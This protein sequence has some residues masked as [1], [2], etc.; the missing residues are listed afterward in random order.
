M[1]K[2]LIYCEDDLYKK[3]PT[4]SLGS[5]F[6]DVLL[7]YAYNLNT[8]PKPDFCLMNHGGLRIPFIP[9]GIITV[10]TA[11]ELMPFENELV[12]VT[13]EGIYCKKLFESI[14]IAGG[15]P[16]SGLKMTITPNQ[17]AK[18]ILIN[19]AEFDEN[20]T[21]HILTSD[22]LANGGDKAD[23]LTQAIQVKSL[24]IKIRDAFISQLQK[25]HHQGLTIKATNDERI[26]KSKAVY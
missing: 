24:N 3:L 21:Y 15:A 23:A 13:L 22:Y 14:A 2:E 6:C 5:M 10:N 20:K 18:N 26:I 11:F 4:G 25:M 1:Q 17:E 16:V 7:N 9:K 12:I 19:N 8:E